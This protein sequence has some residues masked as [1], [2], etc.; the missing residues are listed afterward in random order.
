MPVYIALLRGINVGGQKTILMADLKSL[1][2]SFG[3]SKVVT[4]IQSGNVVFLSEKKGTHELE[5]DI[6]VAIKSRFKFDVEVLV[7]GLGDLERIVY[8]N[9]FSEKKLQPNA[10]EPPAQ[11]TGERIYFTI[12]SGKPAKEKVTELVRLK[13]K[14]DDFEVIDR[15]VYLLCR[16]GY[17]KSAFNNNSIEKV[18][19]VHGTTRNLETIKKLVEIGKNI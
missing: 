10:D 19:K 9:P 13:N 11:K 16:K 4:Y 6:K 15:T 18:L 3:F 17:A 7:L 1:F 2:D 12:L 14:I 8:R 5:D